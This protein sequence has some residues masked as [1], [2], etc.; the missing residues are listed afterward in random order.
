MISA[1]AD[2]DAPRQLWFVSY[3]DGAAHRITNDLHDYDSISLSADARTIAA[4]QTEG[5]FSIAGAPRSDDDP[6]RSGSSAHG[7]FSESA[8]AA[9]A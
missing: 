2:L 5:T 3:P 1:L 8:A 4:V 9:K 6:A 7:R